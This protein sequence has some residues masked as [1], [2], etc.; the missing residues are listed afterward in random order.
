[1]NRFTRS[2]ARTVLGLSRRVLPTSTYDRLYN[3]AFRI[4]RNRL[5]STYYRKVVEAKSRGDTLAATRAESV[6]AVMPYSLVGASGLE[7]TYDLAMAAVNQ[8]LVGSFVECG[9]AQGG[10]AALI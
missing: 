10:C 8:D 6:H 2:A 4:Y 5:R 7:A 1:M 9:V 3:F